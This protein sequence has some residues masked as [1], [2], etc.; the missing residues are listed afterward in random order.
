MIRTLLA[1][2]ALL[3]ASHT[4]ADP[5]TEVFAAWD[6]MVAAKSYRAEMET[7]AAG[8]TFKQTIEVIIPDHFRMYGG[9]GG[10]MILTPEGAWM[11]FPGQDAWMD[12]PPGT[13]EM[14]RQFMSPEFI[15]QAK[16][17]IRSVESLGTESV[18]DRETR[19]YQV[20]Q[21]MTVMGIESK[22]SSRLYV[23]T[24]SGRPVRQE[25]E[26]EAMGQRSS[27]RQEIRYVADLEIVAPK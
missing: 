14:A 23:D 1:A 4:S 18:G 21:V 10:E 6:A 19:V 12:A 11:K 17:G 25:I 9:P 16:A 15:E 22:T 24:A 2:T 26:S 7:T 27:T 20:E 5:K 8:Q 3:A 13:T